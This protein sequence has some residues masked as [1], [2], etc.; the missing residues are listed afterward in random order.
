MYLKMNRNLTPFRR[1]RMPLALLAEL[2]AAALQEHRPAGE[3]VCEAVRRYLEG[4]AISGHDLSK[5]RPKRSPQKGM[6]KGSRLRATPFGE[7]IF[8][9]EL[10]CHPPPHFATRWLPPA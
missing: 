5:P 9:Y 7:I 8:A 4:A 3:L 10:V 6:R 2:R 1:V